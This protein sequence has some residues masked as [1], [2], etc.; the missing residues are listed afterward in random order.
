MKS[1]LI[2]ALLFFVALSCKK[3]E[4]EVSADM[5]IQA[6]KLPAKAESVSSDDYSQSP[7]EKNKVIEK[8]IIKTGNLR[9]QT[10]NLERFAFQVKIL[11]L[12]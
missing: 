12:S 6:V 1:K 2:I 4:A 10:E 5:S 8:K 11:I 7:T 9:F 3:A